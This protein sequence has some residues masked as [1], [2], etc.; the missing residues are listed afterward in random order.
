MAAVTAL[1]T[2]MRRR[3]EKEKTQARQ[4][5]DERIAQ[6]LDGE[7]TVPPR[8]QCLAGGGSLAATGRVRRGCAVRA[9]LPCMLAS[10]LLSFLHMFSP[11]FLPAMSS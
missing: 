6:G 11:L 10:S 9:V 7:Y 4:Q 8:R 2:I 1:N 3:H 5:A